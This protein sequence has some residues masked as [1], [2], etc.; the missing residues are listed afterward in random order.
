MK[1]TFGRYPKSRH[2]VILNSMKKRSL[3][4]IICILSLLPLTA[5]IFSG[6]DFTYFNSVAPTSLYSMDAQKLGIDITGYGFLGNMTSG[7]YLRFGV[8]S[9]YTTLMKLFEEENPGESGSDLLQDSQMGETPRAPYE[10]KVLFSGGPAFRRFVSPTLSWY[11]GMG[12]MVEQDRKIMPSEVE[13]KTE[14]AMETRNTVAFDLDF[15]FRLSA[16]EHSVLRIGA[17]LTR[18]LFILTENRYGMEEPKF[19][20]EQNIFNPVG[21]VGFDVSGYISLGHTYM[22]DSYTDVYTYTITS[23]E[24]GTGI[25]EK[26]E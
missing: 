15:G 26:M 13:T 17:Y 20:F 22:S 14:R 12:I 25:Y 18:P 5:G 10:F 7:I 3:A 1:N 8:Q 24:F 21:E 9:P 16:H 23:S 6:Y 19:S 4:L 2:D 11:M